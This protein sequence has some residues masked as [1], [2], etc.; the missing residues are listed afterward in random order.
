MAKIENNENNHEDD[1]EC[2][3]I[4]PEDCKEIEEED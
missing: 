3:G 2:V 1:T 4:G